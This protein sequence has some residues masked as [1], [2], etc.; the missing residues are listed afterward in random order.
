MKKT[1]TVKQT[2]N[3]QNK[4]FVIFLRFILSLIVSAVYYVGIQLLCRLLNPGNYYVIN[5]VSGILSL[6]TCCIFVV[7]SILGK[8]G[9]RKS[10]RAQP[11]FKKIVSILVV[12]CIVLPFC[13]INC[14][15][16]ADEESIKKKNIF[17]SVTK[18]YV[19]EDIVSVDI[20]V[21]GGIQY[22]IVFSSGKTIDILSFNTGINTF[23]S[24]DNLIM[25]DKSI[26]KHCSKTVTQ[27]KVWLQEW[28]TRRFFFT[29]KGFKYFDDI[30][31]RNTVTQ[32]TTRETRGTVLLSP[33]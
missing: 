29:E 2:N 31:N 33:P 5:T 7:H 3:T 11:K 1:T 27:E 28:N 30:F 4:S 13:F 17:G 25:F 24:D 19:Y 20:S 18:E 12:V 10:F 21:G 15:T 26:S 6:F 32:E 14:C 22:E 8:K 23:L 16:I 9:K